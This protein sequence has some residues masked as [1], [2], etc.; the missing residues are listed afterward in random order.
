MTK[1]TIEAWTVI[2]VGFALLSLMA[3]QWRDL[4]G[5]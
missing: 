2:G 4:A 3:L 5:C 1:M